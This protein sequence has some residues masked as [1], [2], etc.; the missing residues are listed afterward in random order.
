MRIIKLTEETKAQFKEELAKRSTGRMVDLEKKV[1]DIIN[2]VRSKGDQALFDYTKQFD[3]FELNKDN[4]K[5]TDKEI[6]DAVASLDPKFIEVLKKSADNIKE[7]HEKQRR[8]SWIDTKP[9]GSILGQKFTPIEIAGIYVPGGKAAY[10]SS[11]LMNA[12]TAQV[13][14]VPRIIM[15]TPCGKDGKVNPATLAAAK[16]AGVTEIYKVG[17]AQAIAAMAYGTETVPK[18]YKICGPGNI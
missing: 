16:T 18:T 14:G 3:G 11:L 10:P 12:V 17:G 7:F 2:N 8:I 13:A 4:I 6:E 15:C 5:V 1:D 9:D